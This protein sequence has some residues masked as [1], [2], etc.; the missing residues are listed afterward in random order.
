MVLGWAVE[1]DCGQVGQV[2]GPALLPLG[3]GCLKE[4]AASVVATLRE[5]EKTKGK[6]LQMTLTSVFIP[7]PPGTRIIYDRKFLME[8]RN[9]PVTKTPPKDLPA[10]PGVTSPTSDEPPMQVSQSHLHSP[11]DKRAGGGC[12]ACPGSALSVFSGEF[13]VSG[14]GSD[15][16]CPPS[17]E[18]PWESLGGGALVL[19]APFRAPRTLTQLL[20]DAS[21]RVTSEELMENGHGFI[22]Y[23]SS[24]CLSVSLLAT[25]HHTRCHAPPPHTA[26]RLEPSGCVCGAGDNLSKTRCMSPLGTY[27]S[28]RLK[29]KLQYLLA[30]AWSLSGLLMET[31]RQCL[32]LLLEL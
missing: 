12:W 16:D 8:C 32:L 23:P 2:P 25:P 9:S 10:I 20:V 3:P 4:P 31:G 19:L 28:T 21:D 29:N 6:G 22:Q 27:M 13:Q 11:E 14:K 18:E 17:V 1:Q 15:G 30:G 26:P 24:A 5:V 7:P